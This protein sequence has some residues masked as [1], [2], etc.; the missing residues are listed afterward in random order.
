[1]MNNK[2]VVAMLN[3]GKRW[4]LNLIYMYKVPVYNEGRDRLI[5]F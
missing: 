4:E 1:M 5:T 2:K 3:L